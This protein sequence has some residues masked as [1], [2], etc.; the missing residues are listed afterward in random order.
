MNQGFIWLILIAVINSLISVYY[1]LR[2][3]IYMYKKPVV[4]EAEFSPMELPAKVALTVCV[5]AVLHLGI[6]PGNFIILAE[7]AISAL[8]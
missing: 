3:V 6:L 8:F 4:E 5:Y 1:Y 2:V 7:E